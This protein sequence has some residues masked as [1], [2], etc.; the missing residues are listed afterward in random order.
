METKI[1]NF[2]IDISWHLTKSISQLEEFNVEW[3]FQAPHKAPLLQ[4][5]KQI[6]TIGSVGGSTRIEGARMS[7][8]QIETFLKNIDVSK[9][10]DRDQQE[11]ASYFEVLELIS[12]AYPD[13]H[14]T[15]SQIK[16]LHALTLKYSSKD[17][18]HKGNYKQQNNSIQA[19]YPDGST[20]TIFQTTPSGF[21]TENAMNSLI[22]WY[23]TDLDTPTTVKIAAFVY[24]FLSIHPFQDGNGRLS[25]LLSILL[26]LKNNYQW[27]QYVSLEHEIEQRKSEYYQALQQCQ[28]QR[29]NENITAWVTFFLSCL[30]NIQHKLKTKLDSA[31]PD[32]SLSP[33]E[34]AII[35]FLQFRP[36]SQSSE[37]AAHTLFPLP[38]TKSLLNGL[39]KKNAIKKI[40]N[41][42]STYYTLA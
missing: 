35:S 21:P 32:I 40:G 24:E 1:Y 14:I 20:Y 36:N 13:I 2:T 15:E 39:V 8:A 19:L 17:L 29:P 26:L 37:I 31:Q 7:D 18:W 27:V 9:L 10:L 3:R 38:T 6:A 25:R 34:Q 4:Q 22:H 23:A 11:V 5:L 16:Q 30:T 42:K 28:A 33:K 12:Q 41:G